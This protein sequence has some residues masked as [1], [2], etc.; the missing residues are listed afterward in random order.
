MGSGWERLGENILFIKS[1]NQNFKIDKLE[2]KVNK[3]YISGLFIAAGSGMLYNAA[4][5]LS[6]DSQSE[7]EIGYLLISIAGLLLFF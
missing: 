3:K 6:S 4:A 2:E 5:N 7:A 1:N